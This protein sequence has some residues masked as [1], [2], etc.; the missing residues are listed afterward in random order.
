M[1]EQRKRSRLH[2]S[3]A[4]VLGIAVAMLSIVSGPIGGPA[5]RVLAQ[6]ELQEHIL[7]PG[8]V[9][10]IAVFG[11]ADLSR[12][13]PVRTD[14]KI[15]LPLI[16]DIQAAG[17]T[18]TQLS[19]KVSTALRAFVR[20]PQVTI[21]VRDYQRAF[22]YLVGQAARTGSIEIQRGWT[23]LEVMSVAGGVTP[24]A[25]LRR[26][27]LIRRA[28]GAIIELDL[29]RLLNK[30]DRSLNPVVE[31]GDIIMVPALQNRIMILGAVRAAGAHDMDEGAKVFDAVTL[32]GG[33]VDRA[34]TN[35]IGVIRQGAD[36]KAAITTVNLDR[37]VKGDLSQNI[38]LRN[39][40]IVYIPPNN[41]LRWVDVLGYLGG[42][43][44]IR[45][46]LGTP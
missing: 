24:R 19:E 26:A 13:I 4:I 8:D 10:E 21:T 34:A 3:L 45:S 20:N 6:Q 29:D 5:T 18:T 25:A 38:L 17:L 39:G 12:T 40:D 1:E 27:T 31:P 46:V 28:T 14:G 22:V 15:N 9:V 43:G 32:A 2:S 16:G 36:G 30:G 11:E 7:N 41:R 42:I 44:L 37:F 35:N 23:V 33:P